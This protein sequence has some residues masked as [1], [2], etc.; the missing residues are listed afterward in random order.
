MGGSIIISWDQLQGA[1]PPTPFSHSR[2]LG[3]SG[4]SRSFL[5]RGAQNQNSVFLLSLP[6]FNPKKSAA[7]SYPSMCLSVHGSKSGIAGAA[8][9][10]PLFNRP[11]TAAP[12]NRQARPWVEPAAWGAHPEASPPAS[13]RWE[14][15]LGWLFT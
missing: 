11:P 1:S 14:A 9:A 13:C 4:S 12:S 7:T 5:I 15:G 8:F 2:S 6:I 10:P 3:A